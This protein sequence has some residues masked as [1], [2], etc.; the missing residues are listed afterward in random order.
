MPGW[1]GL[2]LAAW[3]AAILRHV[4]EP[5]S[6]CARRCLAGPATTVNQTGF[7]IIYEDRPKP[8]P[9]LS[10]GAKSAKRAQ[11]P[12]TVR[13]WPKALLDR[14]QQQMLTEPPAVVAVREY[15]HDAACRP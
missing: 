9:A 15:G 5:S 1:A 8:P 10:A 7:M 4:V 13:S 11:S 2:V 14:H 3:Y 12:L 6:T